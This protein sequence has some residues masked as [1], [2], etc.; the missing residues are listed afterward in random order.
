MLRATPPSE[1]ATMGPG[2]NA[3]RSM[4]APGEDGVEKPF[5]ADDELENK[6]AR[7]A[8]EVGD[9]DYDDDEDDN[10]KPSDKEFLQMVAEADSQSGDYLEQINRKS[11][12]RAYKAY[13]QEHF[14]GSKYG[15][16]DYRNRSKL[17]VPKTRGA[18]RKDMAA[19]A[20][21]LFGSIDAVTCSPGNEGDAQQ[22]ASAAVIQEL[23]NYRT[24]RSD[25]KASIPWFHIAMGA[26]QTSLLTG[27]CFSKQSWKLEMRKHGSEEYQDEE[28]GET[29]QRDVYKPHID[30][31]Q[32]QLI[33][34]E[35]IIIDKAA[36]WTNPA[37]D[38]AYLI[39]KWPM[40]LDEIH[41][42]QRDPR[43]PWKA[44]SLDKL[45]SAGEGS[46]MNASA[47]RR[48]REQG[49]DRFDEK[50]NP[51]NFDII[52]VWET[53][54]RVAG[55]DWTFL[56]VGDQMMLTD[57]KPVEEVY[58][59]QFG[60]RPLAFGYGGFEAFSIF[61]MSAAESWQMLQQESNDIRNLSL[62]SLKQSIMPVTKVVR[63][64]NVDMD[65]LKRRGQ[66]TAIM[67]TSKDDVTWE[68]VPDL[69][70]GVQA[71]SQKID[72]EFDDLAGQQNYG[73]VQDNNSLGKTLG[74]LKLAAGA[75]NAVQEF[76]I[77]IWIETFCE[78]V[79]AQLV[80]LEQYY[81]S[82]AVV[83]G[84]CADRAQLLQKFGI[85]KVTNELLE[86]TI[87]VRVNIGL[88]A[89]DPQQRLAKFNSATQVALPLMQMSQE[90][91]SGAM[92]ID[93]VAVMTEIFGAAG[94]RDGGKR[95]VK[96]GQQKQP[97]QDPLQAPQIAKLQS[98][99]EKN[100]A[101]AK[102]ALLDALSNA[103][104]VGINVQQLAIDEANADFDRHLKHV[105][106]VG[107]AHQMGFDHGHKMREANSAAA[108]LN[109]DGTPLTL[110]DGSPAMPPQ[111]QAQAP[112]ADQLAQP[113]DGPGAG[114]AGL[115]PA[116]VGEHGVPASDA[117]QQRAQDA[118]AEQHNLETALKNQPKRRTVSITKRGADGRASEFHIQEH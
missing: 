57:P 21:S 52:W 22:R 97:Q 16:T 43:N 13:H 73:T 56:S 33:P 11:W 4:P 82:D 15:T 94:Y 118:A 6:A 65:Q 78:P 60:E 103:A 54:M 104:K 8:G 9:D 62:D 45:R 98:E 7:A 96:Q 48:A 102:K 100:K 12:E 2:G 3:A 28:S 42:K 75:A 89:G 38:A 116:A 18:I 106:Q 69:S 19:V 29:R 26:R 53:Y 95:F 112:N 27:F 10:H 88:G 85:D 117:G 39:I 92:E 55:E 5:E 110:P 61:P 66:G 20:A 58:P 35:N 70:Q 64:R 101:L 84:L 31:P 109:P 50:N 90:F 71:L 107:K 86:N 51:R 63:G 25:S 72:I 44:I 80:R 115:D 47:I 108:G 77:R 36:D 17:F 34:P 114:N 99:T 93:V 105:D 74:G 1:N 59:E 87:N 30:R 67:V 76:D 111:G 49:N 14:Q 46:R 83:L 23:V 79:L 37:Q 68:K 40:R 32:I 41:R 24:D 113:A 91:Q 81:E